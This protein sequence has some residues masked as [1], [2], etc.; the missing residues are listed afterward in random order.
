MSKNIIESVR[1][2][3]KSMLRG[4][5]FL[6]GDPLSAIFYICW[7]L[8]HEKNVRIKNVPR[9]KVFLDFLLVIENLGVKVDWE[10]ES[11][12]TFDGKQEIRENLVGLYEDY[13]YG[14]ACVLIPIA[15]KRH[16]ECEVHPNLRAEVK[17]FRELGVLVKNNYN[18]L[19]LKL[20]LDTN[21]EVKKNFDLVHAD[22]FMVASRLFTSEMFKNLSIGYDRNDSI[23]SFYENDVKG[24]SEIVE[25]EASFSQNEFNLYASI[26]SFSNGEVSLINFNLSQSLNFLLSLG[27]IGFRYEVSNSKLKIWYAGIDQ[28][29]IID[30]EGVSFN[31]LCHLI[32]L[33]SKVTKKTIKIICISYPKLDDLI[34]DLNIMGFR[35]ES[36]SGKKGF[37]LVTVKPPSAFSSVKNDINDLSIGS[38][39]LAFACFYTGNTTIS[40][41]NIIFEYMPYLIDNLKSLTLDILDKR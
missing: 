34:T 40:G 8:F 14:F 25:F 38:T 31:S 24:D 30:W 16:R 22:P 35:I 15:L 7:A 18:I 26:A 2:K 9:C 12:V 17:F 21:F 37:S 23:F 28:P 3:G 36:E 27:E 6:S 10:N 5:V 1:I 19:N 32:L 33:L 41:F 4:D 39:I 20:P 11:T 29:S 13:E